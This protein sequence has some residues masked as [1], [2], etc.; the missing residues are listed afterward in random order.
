M[1]GSH[2]TTPGLLFLALA[3]INMPGALI[4]LKSPL[5][6][7]TKKVKGCYHLPYWDRL[8]K[9]KLLSIQR[10]FEHY[11]IIYTWKCLNGL[12]P[13][14]VLQYQDLNPWL[15]HL[16]QVHL[17][18]GT[19]MRHRTLKESSLG[20]EGPQLFNSL[21]AALRDTQYTQPIFKKYLD[22]LL[23][24]IPDQLNGNKFEKP[25][26][27]DQYCRS[28]NSMKHWMR[29]LKL[30]NWNP[31][32]MGGILTNHRRGWPPEPDG[33]QLKEKHTTTT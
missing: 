13:N 22:Q 27:T 25:L 24:L 32:T 15:G 10:R 14:I 28:S 18:R 21:P 23:M 2:T 9:L 19:H 33:Y 17:T 4:H 7:F 1:E 8:K 11:R 26:P 12:T 5:W 6:S 16:V 20:V 29:Q 31:D 3:P 30:D